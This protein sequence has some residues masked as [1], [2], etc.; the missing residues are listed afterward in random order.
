[1]FE[2][3]LEESDYPFIKDKPLKAKLRANNTM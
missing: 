3:K 2:G 1:M